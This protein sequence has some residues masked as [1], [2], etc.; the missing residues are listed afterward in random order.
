MEGALAAENGIALVV[1]MI[2]LPLVILN[3]SSQHK[4]A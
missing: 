2:T 3:L 1:T 4:K